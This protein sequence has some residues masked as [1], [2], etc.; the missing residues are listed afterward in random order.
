MFLLLWL[1]KKKKNFHDKMVTRAYL[2]QPETVPPSRPFNSRQRG[3]TWINC[4]EQRLN[5]V[6]WR[7]TQ[8]SFCCPARTRSH[9][10]LS[11]Q[12]VFSSNSHSS[13]KRVTL[14]SSLSLFKASQH[15]SEKKIITVQNYFWYILSCGP[16]RR[17]HHVW[18]YYTFP[19]NNYLFYSIISPLSVY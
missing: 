9:P 16:L 8:G 19:L 18:L 10:T 7:I 11:C 3:Y 12:Q 5:Y 6:G 15:K 2:V 13:K 14:L 17:C 4:A 1:W